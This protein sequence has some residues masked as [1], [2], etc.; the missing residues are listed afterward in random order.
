VF[1]GPSRPRTTPLMWEWRFRI[2]GEPFH[3]SPQLA[4]RDGDWK[5]YVN[6]DGSRLELYDLTTDLTQ[7]N[8]VAGQHPDLA[9]KLRDQVIAWQQTLP[10]GPRD[11]NAGQMNYG[12]PGARTPP[13]ARP[14][15]PAAR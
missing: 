14:N 10:Q 12:Y 2:A 9:A 5:L 1:T 8:N 13:R 7:L 3:H 6:P 15:A 4:I 11:P